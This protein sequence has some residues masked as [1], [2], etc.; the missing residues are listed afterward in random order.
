MKSP[1][2]SRRHFLQ[3]ASALAA[4][5]VVPIHVLAAPGRP[6]A[7]DRIDLGVIGV[8]LRGRSLLGD[9]PAEGRV[10]AISDCYRPR[11]VR[12][13]RP[14]PGSADGQSLGSFP[15]TDGETCAMYEDYRRMIGECRLDAVVIAAC[16]HHHVLAATLACQAGLDVYCEKPLSLTIAEGRRL[17]EAV[18]RYG[19]VLQ[20]G[21][22]QRSMEMDRFACQFVRKGGLGKIAW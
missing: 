6:G 10:V 16:D 22:Q 3:R 5:L 15:S 11:M 4:P 21:S 13:C 9:M 19:R 7:N 20:V 12:A 17:A 8:G 14:D 1:R 2:V 18:R